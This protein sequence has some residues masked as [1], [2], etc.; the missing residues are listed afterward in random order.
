MC[1]FVSQRAVLLDDWAPL[2]SNMFSVPHTHSFAYALRNI[3]TTCAYIANTN[4]R[5]P[6]K[7]ICMEASYPSS[8]ERAGAAETVKKTKRH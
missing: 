3:S 8:D 7:D 6:P 4:V 2:H 1:A 5:E